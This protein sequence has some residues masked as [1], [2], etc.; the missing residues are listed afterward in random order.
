M[1]Y[2]FKHLYWSRTYIIENFTKIQ[3]TASVF[4]IINMHLVEFKIKMYTTIIIYKCVKMLNYK[5]KYNSFN[6]HLR[7]LFIQ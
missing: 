1:S 6:F 3:T 2:H 4:K 5:F 7:F